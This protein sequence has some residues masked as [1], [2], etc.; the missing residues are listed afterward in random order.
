M[1]E[2]KHQEE[3]KFIEVVTTSMKKYPMKDFKVIEINT[4]TATTNME[5]ITTPTTS[6]VE[7]N[8]KVPATVEETEAKIITTV[9]TQTSIAI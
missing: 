8:M 5:A 2:V 1:V 9:A 6:L 7:G 4:T 3:L